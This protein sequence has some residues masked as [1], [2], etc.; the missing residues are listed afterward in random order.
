MAG[1]G[2]RV[3]Q[4]GEVLT[5]ALVNTYLQDQVVCR[6]DDATD[7]DS[8]FGGSGQ[9]VL[10]EGRICYLDATNELQYY[11]GA[12]W[13]TIS[14]EAVTSTVLAKGDLIVGTGLN[15]I[16]NLTVGVNGALLFADS[17]TGTGLKWQTIPNNF[18]T[19]TMIADGSIT[20][21]KIANGTVVEAEI[22][23]GAVTSAKIA[24]G[25]IVDEDINASAQI[26]ITKLGTSTTATL[27]VG[28]IELGHASDTTLARGSAGRL[29]VEGVNVV[30]TS[31]TDTLT[32]KTINLSNNTVTGTTAQ[33]NAALSDGDFA[34][35]GGNETL[36]NKTLTTPNIGAATG[37]SLSATGGTILVR[38]A[39]N[40]DG[41]QLQ[42]RAGGT[43]SYEVTLTP[44]T[45]T[46][47]RTLTLP[48]ADGT[49]AIGGAS[50]VITLGTHTDG[51]Y[52][53]TIAGTTDQVTVTGSG[54]ETAS[55]TLS[56]PQSIATTSNPT[57]A[58]VTADVVRI[59]ITANNE[60]DTSSGNLV[61]DSAGGTVTVDDSLI[62]SG[63]LTVNGTTT[64]VNTAT[65]NV[66]DN[67]VVLNN[68]VTGTPTEN[69]GIEVERG[70][71]TN[72][73]VR[74]NET[75][76]KWQL[77]NDGTNYGNILTSENTLAALASTTSSQL[78][79]IISDETGS[80]A[81]VFGTSPTIT[82]AAGTTTTA[83][84]GAGYMG[85]PQTAPATS[86]P[87][88]LLASDAGKHIYVTTT[89]TVTIPANG[90]TAF[91]IGTTIVIVSANGVTT[92]VSITT[93]TLRL[94]NST[95]T[96]NRTIASNG[97][98]TL[99]K[100]TSTLWIISGNGVT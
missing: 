41:V 8:S 21:D 16:D 83:T 20:A 47:D 55:V 91:P 63:D 72:V 65:L 2:V 81:L 78:A 27:G 80:G 86:M 99:L 49:I 53:A 76:D 68:D 60:I 11:D 17:T 73:L 42:G 44:T 87:Y 12:A 30:T 71:S 88:T 67:I 3:F 22:A 1:A 38:A 36:T 61:I 93:D 70:T 52:V 39:S 26:A 28:T 32:G 95:S 74:W 48:N 56:L 46:A 7:R 62:V 29:T 37:T 50:G 10:E 24:N 18:I 90:T 33:F 89:G 45:L 92:T 85:M 82:P 5:A 9:P 66:S 4:P 57:F 58:G 14:P 98:A 54:T 34:T 59:G 19:S 6:F 100:L 75:D 51:N 25:T 64:T 43:S 40:Q 35:I 15:S 69:A 13:V 84:T 23:D 97:M 79:G 96:G 77:T 94:A 31:S